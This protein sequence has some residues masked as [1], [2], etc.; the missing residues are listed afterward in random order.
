MHKQAALAARALAS[1]VLTLL[2]VASLGCGSDQP[3][4][5]VP[6]EGTLS[7]EDGETIP[8]DGI[9]LE[10]VTLDVQPTEEFYPRPASAKLDAKGV[11]T[12]ATSYKYGD[13]LVPGKHKVAIYYATDKQGN[14]LVPKEFT[15][16]TTTPLIIDAADSP[17]EIKV[18]KP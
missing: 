16:I 18:P 10:F 11:F 14:L 5:Y 4:K 9:S 6:V 7:Y 13:G 3:F 15:H 2:V 17:L 8:A 1:S 12:C